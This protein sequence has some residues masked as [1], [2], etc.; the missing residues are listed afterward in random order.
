M[1]FGQGFG[2][3]TKRDFLLFE[4]LVCICLKWWFLFLTLWWILINWYWFNSHINGITWHWALL[5]M[6]WS[7][8][9][10]RDESY[11]I[12]IWS[13]VFTAIKIGCTVVLTPHE[14]RVVPL[15]VRAH[16]N[17]SLVVC[18]VLRSSQGKWCHL[19]LIW[20][21]DRGQRPFP[22]HIEVSVCVCVFGPARL[23]TPS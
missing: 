14:G 20:L 13:I 9:W 23:K 15:S 4:N 5:L 10:S 17:L 18:L 19:R 3:M 21:A 22:V 6:N 11:L 1:Y 2:H 8:I 7:L 12:V 16:T